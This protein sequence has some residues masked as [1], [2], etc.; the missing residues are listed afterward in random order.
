M[1]FLVVVGVGLICVVF[2]FDVDCGS[3]V[4]AVAGGG[5]V[6]DI[7]FVDGYA[8]ATVFLVEHYAVGG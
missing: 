8:F 5:R 1:C 3:L 6:L 4:V 2:R 7:C